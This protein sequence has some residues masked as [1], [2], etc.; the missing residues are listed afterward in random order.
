MTSIQEPFADAMRQSQQAMLTAFDSWTKMVEQMFGQATEGTPTPGS[1]DPS[2]IVDQVFDFAGQLLES[3]R[4]FAKTLMASSAEA[5]EAA[6]PRSGE[7]EGVE[8][9]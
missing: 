4:Q 1:V 9:G 3:Q 6:R 5:L 7:G 2:Q 8:G